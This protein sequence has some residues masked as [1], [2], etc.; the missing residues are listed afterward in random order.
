M[1][2]EGVLE[3]IGAPLVLD[4]IVLAGGAG[5]RFGGGKLLA[6]WREGLLIE[7]ALDAAFAAPVRSVILVTG[8]DDGVMPVALEYALREGEATR[9]KIVHA[10]DHAEGMG[11]SL[12]AG[13]TA[14]PADCGGVF[15]FLG[16]M[17]KVPANVPALL[18]VALR[19]G[20]PAAVPIFG[21]RR[22]H[23]VLFGASL[24]GDLRGV[25]GD[26]GARSVLKR[27]GAAV[28]EV[29][30]PSNGILFDVDTP[31]ALSDAS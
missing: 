5:K 10:H 18:A 31:D 29:P 15:V 24:F 30:A 7:A 17:P 6:P 22:G 21:G 27:L 11:A 28:A 9:L 13:V 8:A 4:A 2:T 3:T 1:A 25:A 20:A 26:E 19:K 14:L 23:P 16:D 12:R